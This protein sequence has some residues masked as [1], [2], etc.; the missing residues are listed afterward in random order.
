MNELFKNKGIR[1]TYWAI[2]EN[3]PKINQEPSSITLSKTNKKI[4]LELT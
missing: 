2:V 4:N 1:K 3:A